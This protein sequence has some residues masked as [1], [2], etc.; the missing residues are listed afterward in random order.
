MAITT[1]EESTR[2]LDQRFDKKYLIDS[3]TRVRN[4]SHELVEPLET[5]DYVIQAMENTSPAKWHLAHTSWFFE[6]FILEKALDDYE[7]LHPKY[8][9]LFNSYYLQTGQPHN[10]SE[11]GL[12]SRPTVS[13]VF[14][15]REYIDQQVFGFLED[16]SPQDL[17]QWG[18]VVEIGINHEQQHQELILTDIKYLF[19]QNPL[20]PAYR[21]LSTNK[22]PSPEELDWIQ[23]DEG[24]YYVGNEGGEFT[25][26]NEHPRHRRFLEAFAVT[27]RLI[28]NGEYLQ[29]IEDDGYNRSP[30]WLDDGW[31][32]VN[33]R[34]WNAPLYWEK[35]GG[36]WHNFTLGGMSKVN[37]DEPVTHLSYYEADAFA[38]WAGAR[39]PT[40]GEWETIAGNLPYEGNF[41]D[42]GNY[43][44]QALQS[45]QENGFKQV[46]GDVWEWT[47]SAYDPYPG[48]KPLEG[49]L[50]EYN[51]KFMC[52]Q[53]V[54]RGGSCATSQSHIRKTY[55][56]F[57][58]PDARWQFNGLRL[59][60]SL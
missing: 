24:I 52:G 28:T 54:L 27:D 47:Q 12:I 6:T 4:F 39:L 53:Y 32:T 7:S 60:R 16:A 17:A 11:R 41:V 2:E 36:D 56:N 5:E 1:E 3:Y 20:K 49:A 55:R 25:Y 8:A 58:Y 45:P 46:Y 43:H 33:E 10:R 9:Y 31:A 50:G 14:E 26:D 35:R 34:D 48:Y 57:F 29:F 37:P 42:S 13:E 40:E 18:P 30:L 23:F 21:N 19:S 38:R 51:G 22:G 59:A 15:Y 44:P